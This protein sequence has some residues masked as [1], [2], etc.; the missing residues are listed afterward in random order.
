M[1]TERR[2]RAAVRDLVDTVPIATPAASA[3]RSRA[4]RR[5]APAGLRRTAPVLAA[6]AVLVVLAGVAVAPSWLARP[7]PPATGSTGGPPVLP[8]EFAG[9]SWRTASVADAPPGP[10]IAIYTTVRNQGPASGQM[11]VVGRDGRTYRVVDG[12]MYAALTD[13]GRQ[14]PL[15]SPDGTRI[16]GVSGNLL[17]LTTGEVTRHPVPDD[18]PAGASTT[19]PALAW[20]PDSRQVAYPLEPDLVP[21]PPDSPRRGYGLALLD[22]TTGTVGILDTD[23]ERGQRV[24][25]SPDGAEIAMSTFVDRDGRRD[26]AVMVFDR[27][28]TLLRVLDPPRGSRLVAHGTA[29]SPDGAF[30]AV[31]GPDRTFGVIDATGSGAPVPGPFRV[32]YP[33]MVEFQGWRGPDEMLIGVYRG[34]MGLRWMLAVPHDGAAMRGVREHTISEFGVD[35]RDGGATDLRLASGLLAEAEVREA[36]RPRHGPLPGW[37]WVGLAVATASLVAVVLACWWRL[38]RGRREDIGGNG[39]VPVHDHRQWTGYPPEPG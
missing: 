28:G 12:E 36:G 37:L 30:L 39:F 31:A 29:W 32:D 19:V 1:S 13:H 23:A 25:F 20:S 27:S 9:A 7:A 21:R 26:R 35:D 33:S 14:A 38:G 34:P 17:D 8:V 18:G 24:A 15:L 10:A 22:T 4:E 2:V 6:A 3:V 16:A 5:R 11:V